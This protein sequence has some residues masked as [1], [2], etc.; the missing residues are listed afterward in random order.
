M[1]KLLS[2]L[3]IVAIMVFFTVA[4]ATYSAKSQAATQTMETISSRTVTIESGDKVEIPFKISAKR[5]FVMDIAIDDCEDVTTGGIRISLKNSKGKRLQ[6]DKVSLE[7]ND[8]YYSWFYSNGYFQKAGKYTYYIENTSDEDWKVKYTLV[9]FSKFAEKARLNKAT[10]TRGSWVKV[11]KI[12]PGYPHAAVVSFSNKKVIKWWDTDYKGNFYVYGNKTG[13]STVTVKLKNGKKY[14][15]KVTVKAQDPNMWAQLYDYDPTDNYFTVRVK[16]CGDRNITII[17][18][19]SYIKHN[20]YS[21]YDRNVKSGKNVIVKPGKTKY[22]RFY[23]NG[24][25]TSENYKK[26][27]LHAIFRYDGKTYKKW[28]VWYKDSW[29][30]KYESNSTWYGSYWGS[31]E[32]DYYEW[33]EY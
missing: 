23:L 33:L 12:G 13:T 22:V 32:D 1:K 24:S 4:I 27:K 2:V 15:A 18:K 21:S 7:D 29:Y 8:Q 11:G 6:N 16:N 26:F 5:I 14:S 17:K 9:A 3:N 30:R 25:S 19:G 31:N 28:K 20:E 10:V